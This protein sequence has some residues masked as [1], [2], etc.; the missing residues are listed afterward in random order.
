MVSLCSPG[1]P[2]NTE[3]LAHKKVIL[4]CRYFITDKMNSISCPF[5]SSIDASTGGTSYVPCHLVIHPLRQ[6]FSCCGAELR[7]INTS[8]TQFSNPPKLHPDSC[9]MPCKRRYIVTHIM[10]IFVQLFHIQAHFS[11]VLHQ[12]FLKSSYKPGFTQM[13]ISEA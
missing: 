3:I 11:L 7:A 8:I 1:K 5:T 9:Q 12:E 10:N 2:D 6:S 13:L 4:Y